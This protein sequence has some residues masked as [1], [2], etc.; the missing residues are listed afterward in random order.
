MLTI[1]EVKASL[2]DNLKKGVKQEFV[3]TLNRFSTDEGFYESYMQNLVNCHS[4]INSGKFR[5][6]DYYKAVEYVSRRFMGLSKVEAF[7]NVFPDRYN[8]YLTNGV[9]NV[10]ILKYVDAY[11]KNLIV[12]RI[13]E[14]TMIPVYISH[15]HILFEAIGV[16][17]EIM[18]NKDVSPKTR[19]DAAAHLMKT[20][21]PPVDTKIQIDVG[22]NGGNQMKDLEESINQL[23]SMQLA[24]IGN[25]VSAKTIA[26]TKLIEAVVVED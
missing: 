13:K 18:T 10:N 15:Q 9:S 4:I 23:V 20:L 21:A 6:S 25:G 24:A 22:I 2:P 1:A 7:K 3:D 17:V 12:S 5:I 26:E 11:D 19:S 16:Q 8:N 14:Q